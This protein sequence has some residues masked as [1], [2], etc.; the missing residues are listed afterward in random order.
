[1]VADLSKSAWSTTKICNFQTFKAIY[2]LYIVSFTIIAELV[3]DRHTKLF[4]SILK[5]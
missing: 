5:F 4:L 1:M 2:R 3:G